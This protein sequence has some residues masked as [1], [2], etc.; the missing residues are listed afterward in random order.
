MSPSATVLV[1]MSGGVDSS[2]AAALLVRQG[3]RVIGAM[4]RLWAAPGPQAEN[5][6][7]TLE[8][9]HLAQGIA[10]QLGIPFHLIDASETFRQQVVEP[11]LE[12]HAQ[13][14]TP[15]PCLICN[16]QVRWQRLLAFAREVGADYLATGHY[17]RLHRLPDGQVQLLRGR[18]L[19][20]D[21]SYVL[22]MLS[23]EQ[24]QRTL[25]PL[26]E[27]TKPEIRR[28]AAE[29]GLPVAQRPDSQDLCFLGGYDY[30]TFLARYRPALIQPGPIL[31]RDGRRL[32]THRGLAF[33]TIGQRR[34][35]G[36]A[37]SEPLYVLDKD[38]T[39][40]ALIVGPAREL[41]RRTLEAYGVNWIAGKPPSL[42]PF[43][44]QVKIRS[45]AQP[46]P[47]TITPLGDQGFRATFDQPLRDITPGQAAVIYQGEICLGGG[48]ILK[49]A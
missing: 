30:R 10:R 26:G 43:R 8:A 39:R 2:V 9:S 36:I 23:Q 35:L 24:L 40:N 25:L 37:A 22:A 31:T 15:N 38:V 21:Q 3:Y 46:A 33:Y 16:R 11:F 32:G 1:A 5:A 29:W 13:A 49:T 12:A 6:C 4:L 28:L 47:A 27:Y 41:G 7:C 44:A 34:G 45:K 42:E 18:D 48:W 19:R 20:K 17:A 14:R